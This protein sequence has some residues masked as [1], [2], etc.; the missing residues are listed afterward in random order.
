MPAP[1]FGICWSCQKQ[2][3]RRTAVWLDGDRAIQVCKTCWKG[4][5]VGRRVEIALAFHD[6]SEK[7]YGI[8]ETL[9]MVRDLI[10]NSVAGY[11]HKF[12]DP[13]NRMN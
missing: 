12:D 13:R 9:A 11:F 1:E 8:E 10:H 2:L 7:G 4:I 6:R 5:S 3:N